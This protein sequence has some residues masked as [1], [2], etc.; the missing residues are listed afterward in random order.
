[1]HLNFDFQRIAC[2]IKA[3]NSSLLQNVLLISHFSI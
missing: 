2:T 3:R 1:M